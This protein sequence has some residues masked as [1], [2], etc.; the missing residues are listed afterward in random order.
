MLCMV[1]VTWRAVV[2]CEFLF[3]SYLSLYK[4]TKTFLK[5]LKKLP[6]EASKIDVSPIS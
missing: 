3:G 5:S 1:V 4:L 6:Q 2:G